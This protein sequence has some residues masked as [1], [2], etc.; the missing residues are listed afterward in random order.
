VRPEAAVSHV[1]NASQLC[2]GGCGTAL[3][4]DESFAAV[5]T[6]FA[7]DP[8]R[9]RSVLGDYCGPCAERVSKANS[10]PPRLKFS[11]SD[12]ERANDEW[13]FNCGPGSLCALLELTPA[14]VRPHLGDFEQKRYTNP[15]LM[16]AA[17][18]SLGV[19]G[20]WAQLSD[21]EQRRV[22][23]MRFPDA[24]VRRLEWPQRG[25]AR[26]QW[27]GPW[28]NHGVPMAA[29]YRQTHWVAAQM[30]AGITAIFDVNAHTACDSSAWTN[31][32]GWTSDAFWKERIAP[33]II[34]HCVPRGDG[35]FWITHVFEQEQ[36]RKTS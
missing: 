16:K 34:K 20:R 22:G 9:K 36:G 32:N 14:E 28:T 23:D 18:G 6:N 19:G 5:A 2:D 21:V 10:G 29:R 4:F 7:T 24:A 8:P 3:R 15:T 35:T 11:Y 33:F 17:L 25:L 27:G 12:A 30:I 13:G 31:R 26:I 1:F